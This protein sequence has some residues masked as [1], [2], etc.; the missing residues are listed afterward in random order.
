MLRGLESKPVYPN[1]LQTENTKKVENV[2]SVKTT[3]TQ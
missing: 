2:E 1:I 3:V